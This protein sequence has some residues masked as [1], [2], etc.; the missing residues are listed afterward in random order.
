[1]EHT[2][3]QNTDTHMSKKYNDV[4]YDCMINANRASLSVSASPH[5]KSLLVFYSAVELFYTNT[6][7]LFETV[8]ITSENDKVLLGKTLHGLMANLKIRLKEMGQDPKKQSEQYYNKTE[9]MVTKTHQMIMY[10]LQAR[11]MLVRMSNREVRGE[12]SIAY[13][14]DIKS[15]EKGHI[16]N[17]AEMEERTR[18]K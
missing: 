2:E 11:N 7:F 10:G 3:N 1:M 5:Y 8:R 9:D 13:W 18:E 6:F 4:I 16:L 14:G 15:F 12:E 17:D